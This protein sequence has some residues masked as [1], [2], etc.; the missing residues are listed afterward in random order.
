M[1][2]G[3]E[4]RTKQ[5]ASW[6]ISLE[7]IKKFTLNFKIVTTHMRYIYL[8]ICR[9]TSSNISHSHSGAPNETLNQRYMQ[10]CQIGSQQTNHFACYEK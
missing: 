1:Y 9:C 6:V 5:E 3:A 7:D 4:C 2:E 10:A 8:D